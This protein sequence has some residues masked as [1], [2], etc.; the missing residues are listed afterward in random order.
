MAITTAAIKLRGKTANA[1]NENK[2][3]SQEWEQRKLTLKEMKS[4]QHP[5]LDSDVSGIFDDLFNAN[6]IELPKMKRSEEAGKINH[7]RYC[8]CHHLVGHPIHNCFFFKDKIMQLAY[9]RKIS[10][11]EYKVTTNLISVEAGSHHSN[12][13]SCNA[14]SEQKISFDEA[15]CPKAET[16]NKIEECMSAMNFTDDDLLLGSKPHNKPLFVAGYAQERRVNRILIDGGSVVNILPLRMMVELG[17]SMDELASSRLMIQGSNQGGQR[18]LGIIRIQLLMDDMS[19]TALFHIIDAKTSYNM[20]L[21]RPWL[22]EN[23]VHQCFKYYKDRMVKI[24]LT[25]DKLFTKA[26]SY[27]ANAK[28]YFEK[29]SKA[30]EDLSNEQD[31]QVGGSKI[32]SEA[33]VN[34]DNGSKATLDGFELPKELILPLTKLDMKKPQPIEGFGCFDPK[35]YKLLFKAGY[36]PQELLSL[37]K[38]SP[39]AAR[40]Q[41]GK[42]NATQSM[43]KRN[44]RAIRNTKMGFE[45]VQRNPIRIAIKRASTNHIVK[46]EVSSTNDVFDLKGNKVKRLSV[47]DRLGKL[48][49]SRNNLRVL[50]VKW[51]TIVFTQTRDYGDSDG[52]SMASSYHVGSST[53]CVDRQ[54]VKENTCK[55]VLKFINE[56]YLD[57]T[58][59][60]MQMVYTKRKGGQLR[61]CVNF[62]KIERA[63]EEVII[64]YHVTF[65]EDAVEEDAEV[66]PPELEEGVKAT[67]DELKEVN[68]GEV[69]DPRPI[70]IN[71]LLI[72][73]EEKAYITLL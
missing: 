59:C 23:G 56:G 55:R 13:A 44:E 57:K 19:S 63:K 54:S 2:D 12:T 20:L 36:N 60:I 5:F 42:F 26:E 48:K 9:Q 35:A 29:G 51:E 68:V 41:V 24:M 49:T 25:D 69:N 4:K 3:T 39:K 33:L 10:L 32:K 47:F 1:S 30:K 52:E 43:L 34:P 17:I 8:E 37:K 31:D 73:T 67:I 28:Y 45:F 15:C 7:P 22:H 46:K 38:Y 72:A 62:Q 21:G 71:A 50:K 61:A 70:Y 53:S 6:L 27:F 66:A 14:T 58:I 16:C 65:S 11:E 18:A 64:A 40:N